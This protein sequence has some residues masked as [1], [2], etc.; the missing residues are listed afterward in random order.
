MNKPKVLFIDDIIINA[1]LKALYSGVYS[2]AASAAILVCLLYYMFNEGASYSTVS[3]LG[4]V[5]VLF[6]YVVRTADA[7]SY[8]H[9]KREDNP[10]WLQR[11]TIFS[12][13]SPIAW[14][15]FLIGLYPIKDLN[16]M[17]IAFILIGIAMSAVSTL[18]YSKKVI[19][20]YLSFLFIPFIVMLYLD[21]NYTSSGILV[22]TTLF[23]LFLFIQTQKLH[24]NYLENIQVK[25]INQEQL[26]EL[27]N[28]KSA[29]DLHSIVSVTDVKGNIT[30]VNDKFEKLSLYTGD[31]LIGKNHRILHSGYNYPSNFYPDM[32]DTLTKG[33]YWKGEIRNRAKD[34][35]YYWILSTIV[36]FMNEHGQP[37]KY[38]AISTDI[39]PVKELEEGLKQSNDLLRAEQLITQQETQRLDT[40]IN[41]AM[42]A[43]IQMNED[44]C[45]VGWNKQAENMFGRSKDE[46]MGKELH[47]LILPKKYHERHIAGFKRY[48]EVGESCH[49][50]SPLEITVL[51]SKGVEFPVKVSVSLVKNKEKYEFSG[52]LHDLRKQRKHEKSILDE[53]EKAKKVGK[54]LIEA[55]K[56][57]SEFLANMSHE[58]RTPMHGILSFAK[59]GVKKADSV[60]KE[61]LTQYF[62]NILM[63]GE[64]LLVLLDDLLDLSKLEAGKMILRKE[65]AN[66][67]KLVKIC[68]VEQ[69]QIMKDLGIT[70]TMIV[71]DDAGIGVFDKAGISQVIVNVLSNAIKFSPEN[72]TI[73]IMIVQDGD[74]LK[75]SMQDQGLGIP[76][77]ELK[78]IFDAFIQSSKTDTGAGG[79]GLGLA[80]CKKIIEGHDGEIWAENGK[81]GGAL[82]TF[83][84][85]ARSN[86]GEYRYK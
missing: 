83:V 69:E 76:Q 63:S 20:Y 28:L 10:Y 72:S 64:R 17:M 73:N 29:I 61:K 13:L 5:L 74:N 71:G 18:S 41:M 24:F 55:N 49:F 62:S 39:T 14:S 52:F 11:F 6:S 84:I 1:Q 43:S 59:F 35:S 44:G 48:L 25:I 56:A 54:E 8:F 23:Y 46:V 53:A 77:R 19:R 36:P 33:N 15:V 27:E 34:N 82:F 22:F 21:N 4:I 85:P 70:V 79:T 66:L 30:Y 26:T 47:P 60:S 16:K 31:E 2:I 50:S 9:R 37:E 42:D 3:L 32:W 75:F 78:E 38:I 45:I 57:K 68:L 67:V 40:I 12:T 65:D 80:I 86:V 51:D 81:N 58:L 7:H